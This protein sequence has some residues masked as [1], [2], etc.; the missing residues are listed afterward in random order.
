M[1]QIADIIL[2]WAYLKCFPKGFMWPFIQHHPVV[3]LEHL[4]IDQIMIF[5]YA[6]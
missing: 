5:M 3:I 1:S 6:F 4:F 2:Q